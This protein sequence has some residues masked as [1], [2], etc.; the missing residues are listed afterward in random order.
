M[1]LDSQ[2]KPAPGGRLDDEHRL[3]QS[4]ESVRN[5][6]K[7]L[8][9]VDVGPVMEQVRRHPEWWN[10]DLSWTAK[11]PKFAAIYAFDYIIL[12]F[13]QGGPGNWDRPALKVFTTVMPIVNEVVRAVGGVDQGKVIITRLR[14]GNEVPKHIDH[15]PPGVPVYWNRYQVPLLADPDVISRCGDED[16]FMEPGHAWWLNNQ[17]PHSIGKSATDRISIL[18]D[19]RPPPSQHP[20]MTVQ[21]Q[22]S[23]PDA[24][25]MAS[26]GSE[27]R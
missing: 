16:V 7:V 22:C 4:M 19:I 27:P 23:S 17:L 11:K 12:R 1:Q 18:V 15:M 25:A 3:G 2:P 14:A 20:W 13:T 8:S 5:F 10:Y 24:G 6:R 26:Y 9:D 21:A